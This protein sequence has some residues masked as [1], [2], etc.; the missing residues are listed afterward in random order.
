MAQ[1]E[2][3][4]KENPSF[5]DKMKDKWSNFSHRFSPERPGGPKQ[6]DMPL[7]DLHQMI[8]MMS[9]AFNKLFEKPSGHN[10]HAHSLIPLSMMQDCKGLIF[11]SMDKAAF[12]VGST[13]GVGCLMIR[14][15]N[16]VLKI[17]NAPPEAVQVQRQEVITGAGWSAPIAVR[18]DALDV[19]LQV[20]VAKAQHI[21]AVRSL[22]FLQDL[23]ALGKVAIGMNGLTIVDARRCFSP[24][25]PKLLNEQGF[26]ADLIDFEITQGAFLGD[27]LKNQTLTVDFLT[28]ASYYGRQLTSSQVL[29]ADPTGILPHQHV[30]EWRTLVETLRQA[31]DKNSYHIARMEKEKGKES[32]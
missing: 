16:V 14:Q 10:D 27:T 12:G 29:M 5:M 8:P 17:Q 6:E 26:A 4:P 28:N 19:G 11:L 9:D 20:G 2:E 1:A 22:K 3:K 18:L 15:E 13:L 25:N 30:E 24:D 31:A 23:F 7:F 21:I 32:T